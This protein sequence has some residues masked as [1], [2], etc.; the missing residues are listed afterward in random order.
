MINVDLA[1]FILRIAAG[2]TLFLHGYG[3][4]FRGGKLPGTAGWFESIGLKPGKL[5]A[6]LATVTEIGAGIALI[7]GF[8][9]PLA[10]GAAAATMVVALI[11]AH[12]NNG[13]FIFNPGQ[14]YEYTLFISLTLFGL[15][16]LGGGRWSLDNAIGFDLTG[17][18]GLATALVIGLGGAAGLLAVYWRPKKEE[19]A[20]A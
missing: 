1:A 2:V 16:A 15:A 3:H 7:F 10:A 6:L 9:T 14:G 8:L 13:F 17:W 12:R 4:A 11:T 20:A 19:P 18:G 5:H